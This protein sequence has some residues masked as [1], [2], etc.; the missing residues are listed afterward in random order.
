MTT[1]PP[2]PLTAPRKP[3]PMGVGVIPMH[4]HSCSEQSEP[5]SRFDWTDRRTPEQKAS[6]Q[7]AMCEYLKEHNRQEI[8]RARHAAS[9]LS[10]I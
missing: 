6:A 2:V 3:R 9:Q 4:S 8:E 10:L 1:C 7:L 5:R